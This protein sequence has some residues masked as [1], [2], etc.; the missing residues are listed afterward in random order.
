MTQSSADWSRCLPRKC[1]PWAR[2]LPCLLCGATCLTGQPQLCQPC[3]H[4]LPWHT[5]PH[6]PQCALATTHGAH[7]G[8]CLQHRPAF[9]QTFAILRYA[10]PLDRLLQQFK[11][12]QR[13]DCG[14]V[15][16]ESLLQ[17][18]PHAPVTADVALAMPMHLNRLKLRG[19]NH[20]AQL[21]TALARYWQLAYAPASV[22]RIK[23]T[24]PQAG[25]DMQIRTRSLRGAFVSQAWQGQH[26]MIVDDVMTT[27]ASMHALAHVIKKAGASR[28]SAVVL[29][30]T[31]K[32]P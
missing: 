6:C 18:W 14:Q 7:C 5:N 24:A 20:A 2:H 22:Q 29:A 1:L 15:L 4:E 11:Y 32:S 10:Y 9:D 19:F 31:L 30:R 8:Q 16:I 27:G 23:D 21:A 12:Q 26:V 13:L 3:L 25:L 17:Q 28:V